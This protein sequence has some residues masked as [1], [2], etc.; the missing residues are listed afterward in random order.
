MTLFPLVFCLFEGDYFNA[1]SHL[2]Q[3]TQQL[4]FEKAARREQLFAESAWP[5]WPHPSGS[6]GPPAQQAIWAPRQS[7]L[8][9]LKVSLRSS[10]SLLNLLFPFQFCIQT[11]EA[12]SSTHPA[13]GSSALRSFHTVCF[14]LVTVD[15][16]V[17]QLVALALKYR[18]YVGIV[19]KINGAYQTVTGA[20]FALLFPVW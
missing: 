7:V 3:T 17:S 19:V 4:E 11:N 12:I 6:P 14:L 8:Q 9:G 20:S 5:T 16:S 13:A 1:S 18:L 15:Q 10:V 2:W